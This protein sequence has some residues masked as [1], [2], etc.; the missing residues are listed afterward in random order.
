MR[1]AI[2]MVQKGEA[3][4][5][6]SAGNTGAL[7]GLSKEYVLK[8]KKGHFPVRGKFVGYRQTALKRALDL[9]PTLKE[10]RG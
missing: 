10:M 5:C 4:G 6:V 9:L 8:G 7:M 2:E 1:L 3:Q